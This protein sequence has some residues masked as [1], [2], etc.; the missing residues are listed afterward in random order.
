MPR[1]QISLSVNLFFILPR[2]S[3]SFQQEAN[4]PWSP[5][6]GEDELEGEGLV[7]VGHHLEDVR[8]ALGG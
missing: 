6:K 7:V 5:S 4:S 8:H 2:D 3:F 1:A